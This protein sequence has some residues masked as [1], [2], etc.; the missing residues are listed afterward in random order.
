MRI[1]VWE[2]TMN[3][4]MYEEY[5]WCWRRWLTFHSSWASRGQVNWVALLTPYW[6]SEKLLSA[7]IT[8]KSQLVVAMAL[9]WHRL[10]TT[11]QT[12]KK[13]K[14]KNIIFNSIH[15]YMYSS[16]KLFKISFTKKKMHVS[17]LQLRGICYQR[18]LSKWCLYGRNVC[19][20]VQM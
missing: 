10:K 16:P 5:M 2:H 14:K 20:C 7:S 1:S 12:K 6:A 3:K 17:T 11:L 13:K 8:F 18:W 19:M 15:V 4:W 9:D